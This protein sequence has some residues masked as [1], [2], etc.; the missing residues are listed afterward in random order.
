MSAGYALLG[1]LSEGPSCGAQLRAEFASAAGE[2]R[3]P[4]AG[5]VPAALS[6]TLPWGSP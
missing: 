2:I 5:Q 1:L 6:P 4:D 3:P